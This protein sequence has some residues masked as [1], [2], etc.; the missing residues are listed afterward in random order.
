MT[1]QSN[2]FEV[3]E[4]YGLPDPIIKY[5][6]FLKDQAKT[7][8]D[9]LIDRLEKQLNENEQKREHLE[10]LVAENQEISAKLKK[11][12]ASLEKERDEFRQKAQEEADAYLEK[13]HAEAEEV[14]KD[15]IKRLP[16]NK[17]PIIIAGG[18]FNAK[19][20]ETFLTSEGKEILKKLMEKVSSEK[21]YFVIGHKMQGYEKAVQV[22][23]L[24]Y[25]KIPRNN[26]SGVF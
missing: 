24:S 15:K 13:V 8:E 3:A 7:E 6:R 1:G 17:V 26:Q 22:I 12:R 5:A 25:T 4:K 14:L 11:E 19:G 23:A 9:I 2:A 16:E 10:E 21:A 18:S 20:R